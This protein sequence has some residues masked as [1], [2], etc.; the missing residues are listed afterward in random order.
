MFGWR[1]KKA[2]DFEW[3]QYV[4]TTIKIRREQRREQVAQ[5]KSSAA[6]G[7]R[8]AADSALRSAKSA[9]RMAA[10]GTKSG[11]T[12]SWHL[13]RL[14]ANRFTATSVK[15]IG[16]VLSLLRQALRTATAWASALT[17]SSWSFFS[18]SWSFLLSWGDWASNL[19]GR[20][21]SASAIRAPLGL[22]GILA[23]LAGLWQWFGHG[24]ETQASYALTIAAIALT[25]AY[26]PTAIGALLRWLAQFDLQIASRTSALARSAAQHIRLSKPDWLAFPALPGA[27]ANGLAAAAIV[28]AIV[29]IGWAGLRAM[30]SITNSMTQLAAQLP[31]ISSPKPI[32]GRATAL[33]GNRLRISGKTIR[34]QG[35][36]APL[37]NQRCK[38]GRRSWRCGRA[39]KRALAR[40]L[41][42]KRIRCNPN[43]TDAH[44]TIIA[45]CFIRGKDIGA[46]LVRRGHIFSAK[47]YLTATYSTEETLAQRDKT[48]LWQGAA[49]RPAAWRA[50]I[51]ESAKR[52]SPGGCPIKG[53]VTRAGKFY[54]LPWAHNYKRVRIRRN[55]G[56][57]WFCSESAARAAGW[58]QRGRS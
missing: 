31:L 25:L 36:D 56:E 45:T 2:D 12:Q 40:L 32:V 46:M 20:F 35:T 10:T 39:A 33:S 57:R 58:R 23:T 13:L 44:G 55:R 41:R 34:L 54:V 38:K 22:I 9:A 3:H 15:L 6:R 49:L 24:F 27:I 16:V 50:Q 21:L 18:S 7:A 11:L 47:G 48:G 17:T 1:K 37:A 5:A 19:S 51:W 8:S 52:R 26:G 28:V 29:A 4:R 30:P 42:R 14:A 43:G 53:D